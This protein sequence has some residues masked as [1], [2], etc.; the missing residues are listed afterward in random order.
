MK[1]L[2][3]IIE[4]RSWWWLGHILQKL[5]KI[6]LKWTPQEN[7]SKSRTKETWRKQR[8]CLSSRPLTSAKAEKK[9]EG[10]TFKETPCRN[11][12]T[13]GYL[14][15]QRESERNYQVAEFFHFATFTFI[16]PSNSIVRGQPLQNSY[17]FQ[18]NILIWT[19]M[20]VLK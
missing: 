17:C 14:K 10:Q 2:A 12:M 11:P 1:P 3:S 7:R 13:P 18:H 5:L 4:E 19:F 20:K 6:A 15:I 9:D 16:I 8:R